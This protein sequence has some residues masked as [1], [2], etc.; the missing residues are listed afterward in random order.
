MTFSVSLILDTLLGLV[1]G[2]A[3][4][5]PPVLV[6]DGGAPTS[7]AADLVTIG[8]SISVPTGEG[9]LTPVRL[10]AGHRRSEHTITSTVECFRSGDA[11]A[12]RLQALT[13]FEAIRVAVEASTALRDM[14]VLFGVTDWSLDQTTTESAEVSE[15]RL[16]VVTWSLRVV[17]DT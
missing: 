16:A 2:L 11:R 10:G 9:S 3:E 13:I 14:T 12:A 15:G 6:C 8:G 7:S 1:S 17:G 5:Q 4:C